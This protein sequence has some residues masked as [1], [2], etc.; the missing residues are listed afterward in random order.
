MFRC[1]DILVCTP[2]SR[3]CEP[4]CGISLDPEGTG[5]VDVMKII[6]MRPEYY[7]ADVS[8]IGVL[9]S[10][11]SQEGNMQYRGRYTPDRVFRSIV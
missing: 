7:A 5:S 9:L 1:I 6:D 8:E 3:E 10:L 4:I 2:C 11:D